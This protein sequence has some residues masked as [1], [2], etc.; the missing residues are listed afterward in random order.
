METPAATSS[1]GV[2]CGR[3]AGF[4]HDNLRIAFRNRTCGGTRLPP[5]TLMVRRLS[6][7]RKKWPN[8]PKCRSKRRGDSACSGRPVELT[9]IRSALK[10]GPPRSKGYRLVLP[11]PAMLSP[12]TPCPPITARARAFSWDATTWPQCCTR[13]WP[14]P[15]CG[16]GPHRPSAC[17]TP[18]H[19][20]GGDDPVT[21]GGGSRAV[22]PE[23]GHSRGGAQG[24]LSGTRRA[25]ERRFD[26]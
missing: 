12:A 25:G 5:Q 13:G 21:H 1:V 8:N 15:A 16:G 10:T 23:G 3:L 19:A 7:S 9:P 4:G 26:S 20:P 22:D 2:P 24:D 6:L 14:T 17:S 11:Q 18:F